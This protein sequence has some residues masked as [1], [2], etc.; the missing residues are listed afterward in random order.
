MEQRAENEREHSRARITGEQRE[1]ERS[2][3]QSSSTWGFAERSREKFML[4]WADVVAWGGSEWSNTKMVT[5]SLSSDHFQNPAAVDLRFCCG[6][7]QK[8]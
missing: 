2:G 8:E 6:A 7:V 1:P 4:V 3:A 5:A